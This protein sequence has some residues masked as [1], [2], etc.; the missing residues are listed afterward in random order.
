V[1]TSAAQGDCVFCAIIDGRLP[2]SPV[3]SDEDVVAFLDIHPLTTGHLLV[4]PRVHAA[5]LAEL[6]EHAGERVFA[7]AHRLALAIRASDVPSEGINL[8][9]ADGA[10]AGQEVFHVHLHVLPRTTDDGFG[11][12]AHRHEAERA[13][14]DATAALIRRRAGGPARAG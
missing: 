6:P 11:V 10:V 8:F 2:S 1:T 14:L 7:A 12:I 3:Y 4:V 9:L 5:G 13:D